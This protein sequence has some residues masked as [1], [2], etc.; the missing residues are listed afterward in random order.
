MITGIVS[1]HHP[2]L[3]RAPVLLVCFLFVQRLIHNVVILERVPFF[4]FMQINYFTFT[5]LP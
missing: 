5:V 4:S 2:A 3:Q 1:G